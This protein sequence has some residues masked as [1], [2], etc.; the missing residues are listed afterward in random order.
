ML[1]FAGLFNNETIS[2]GNIKTY[3]SLN[4][5]IIFQNICGSYT[6]SCLHVLYYTYTVATKFE[7][8]KIK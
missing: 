3:I 7:R 2:V 5:I 4:L 8:N 1:S 6:M